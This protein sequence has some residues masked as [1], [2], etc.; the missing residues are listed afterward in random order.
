MRPNIN[1]GIALTVLLQCFIIV[2][3]VQHYQ[4]Q[5]CADGGSIVH[6]LGLLAVINYVLALYVIHAF[7]QYKSQYQIIN[8]QQ[9]FLDDLSSLLHTVR[10]QR[11]DFIN[12]LQAIYG[13]LQLGKAEDAQQYLKDVVRPVSITS[14][15]LQ[16]NNEVLAVFL[17]SKYEEIAGKGINVIY[18]F[19]QV[20]HI[21]QIPT[22]SMV[23]V[24]GNL[25]NNAAE[26]VMDLPDNEKWVRLKMFC[27][28]TLRIEV[29]NGGHPIDDSIREKIFESGFSTRGDNRGIGLASVKRIVAHMNGSVTFTNFPT[30]FIVNLPYRCKG[31]SQK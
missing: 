22:D 9:Q 12:H 6:F 16:L 5:L 19:N 26:A 21:S 14:K 30:T 24:L 28:D 29:S 8:N 17:Q 3:F 20:D 23:V 15:L 18:D 7:T 13:L 27:K 1:N 25:L 4:F 31:D 11:H 2:V 10:A